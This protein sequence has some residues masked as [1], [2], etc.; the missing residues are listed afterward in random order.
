VGDLCADAVHVSDG[1]AEL[2]EHGVSLVCTV[3]G[4]GQA[5]WR[6]SKVWI[7]MRGGGAWIGEGSQEGAFNALCNEVLAEP[8]WCPSYVYLSVRHWEGRRRRW[9]NLIAC[10]SVA[11][12]RFVDVELCAV[13]AQL[14]LGSC[15]SGRSF[16]EQLFLLCGE[17]ARAGGW[18]HTPIEEALVSGRGLH[19]QIFV[20]H[21]WPRGPDCADLVRAKRARDVEDEAG[22]ERFTKRMHVAYVAE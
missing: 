17:R 8:L 6:L 4:H 14:L 19:E 18:A 7:T 10:L 1:R 13:G 12:F 3:Q 22:R 9:E 5:S 2:V 16:A 15:R 21:R 20:S 11:S